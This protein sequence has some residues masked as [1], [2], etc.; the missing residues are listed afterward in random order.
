MVRRA[1]YQ[2]AANVGV[3]TLFAVC[4]RLQ[5]FA[6]ALASAAQ[7]PADVERCY[8]GQGVRIAGLQLLSPQGTVA[9]F[10][11]LTAL[12][13]DVWALLSVKLRRSIFVRV[14]LRNW[15]RVRINVRAGIWIV[16]VLFL[17]FLRFLR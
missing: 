3:L 1:G 14:G 8:L 17:C 9:H 13:L 10:A 7:Q 6:P 11:L 15:V 5:S 16:A 2:D 12:T 4:H